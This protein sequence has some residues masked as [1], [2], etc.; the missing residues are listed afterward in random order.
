SD[1]A[2]DG[3]G[4]RIAS[5]G[6]TLVISALNSFSPGASSAYVYER[7][8][9]GEYRQVAQ[10]WPQD[11]AGVSY[12]GFAV[13]IDEGTILVGAPLDGGTES[14]LQS[15]TGAVYVY[16]RTAAG[17]W[18]RTARI[19]PSDSMTQ[20][21]FGVSVALDGGRALATSPRTGVHAIER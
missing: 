12:F 13:A 3:F 4:F 11:S 5:D 21:V 2:D 16:E 1:R 7:S 10:L 20:G 14:E 9:S 15:G 6:N 17:T 19:V 18:S 8:P